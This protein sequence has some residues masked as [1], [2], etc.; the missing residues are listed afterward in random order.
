MR[1]K[2]TDMGEKTLA[3]KIQTTYAA[4]IDKNAVNMVMDM[5]S[6]L[7]NDPMCAAIREYVSN[8][9]DANVEADATKPVELTL[10]CTEN[11]GLLMVKDYGRGLDY[12]GIVSVFANFGT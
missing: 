6:K 4:K 5:L 10:P 7:Y 11:D 12:M 9:Y 3:Q 8:A 1:L 2:T